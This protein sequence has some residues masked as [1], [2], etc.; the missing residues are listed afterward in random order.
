MSNLV[1]FKNKENLKLLWDVLLDELGINTSNE[2]IMSNILNIFETNISIFNLSCNYNT[3]IMELN[4]NFLSQVVLAVN[5]LCPELNKERNIKRIKICDEEVIEPYKIEDIHTLRQI[6]FQQEI[7]K[8]ILDMENFKPNK[9][10]ELDFSDKQNE[11]KIKEIDLLIADKIT[12]RQTE[13]EEFQNYNSNFNSEQWLKSKETS[14]KNEKNITEQFNTSQN[15]KLKHISIDNEQKQLK[16][17]SWSDAS[18]NKDAVL[19]DEDTIFGKLKTIKN[20]GYIFEDKPYLEQ[21]SVPLPEI[22]PE[23]VMKT[24]KFIHNNIII[25]VYKNNSSI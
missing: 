15:V 22:K 2:T 23:I 3:D 13:I 4:K 11:S 20:N 12:Q 8:Q 24:Q 16:K 18:V 9:P 17:V 6:Q 10:T 19:S 7:D 5:K 21:K 14:V 25:Y 1:V